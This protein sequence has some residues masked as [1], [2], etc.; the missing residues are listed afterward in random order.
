MYTDE[1]KGRIQA[2][3]FENGVKL[4]TFCRT[5]PGVPSDPRSGGG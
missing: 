3:S 5:R 4:S 2:D 1:D